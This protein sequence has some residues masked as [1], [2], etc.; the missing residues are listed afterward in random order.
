MA[1]YI[2]EEKSHEVAR[3]VFLDS[4]GSDIPLAVLWAVFGRTFPSVVGN[5]LQRLAD[6]ALRSWTQMKVRR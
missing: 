6:S 2:V 4:S 1:R 3:N 5:I